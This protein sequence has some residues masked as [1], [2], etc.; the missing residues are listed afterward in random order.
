VATTD[1]LAWVEGRVVPLSEARLPLTDRGFLFAD[2]VFDTVRT[3]GGR[4]FLLGDH[5]D[6]LRAS[7][8]AVY[9]PV[10][11]R[12]EELVAVVDA[13][14]ESFE[15]DAS[16]RIMVTRGDGG[17]GLA[18]P[19]PQRPRLVALCR[20]LSLP[21]SEMYASGVN[22]VR[23]T[24]ATNKAGGVPADIK[25]GSYLANVLALREARARGG[26]EALLRAADGSWAEATTSNLFGVRGGELFTPAVAGDILPGITRALVLSV[27][28]TA[29][30]PCIERPL[31]DQDLLSADELFITSSIKEVLPVTQVDG[32]AVGEG[33]P[34]PITGRLSAGFTAAVHDLL[35]AGVTRL[36]D[37][38]LPA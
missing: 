30:I 18:L 23:P 32:R 3:Y 7:A 28:R 35:S 27:A 10:P 20:P 29:G 34:G 31:V 21:N 14:L 12:D 22:I 16:V 33:I 15:G 8:A 36:G 19:E 1:G 11:W 25:S 38:S 17:S 26:Y 2:S 37:A 13:L 6:R 24:S 9:L 4:A 5:I